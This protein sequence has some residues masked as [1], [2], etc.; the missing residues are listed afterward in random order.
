MWLA[1]RT[2]ARSVQMVQQLRRKPAR[3]MKGKYKT[4]SISE[5]ATSQLGTAISE[6]LLEH[7]GCVTL[8]LKVELTATS[9][10]VI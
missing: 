10:F 9:L 5:I 1:S 4:T 3:C 7:T 2:G 8:R 6:I